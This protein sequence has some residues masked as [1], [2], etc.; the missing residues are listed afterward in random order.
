MKR[1][2]STQNLAAKLGF[3]TRPPENVDELEEDFGLTHSQTFRMADYLFEAKPIPVPESQMELI[4]LL[5]TLDKIY[6]Y[7][8]D[9]EDNAA[10]RKCI[11]NL[12]HSLIILMIS[13]S[14]YITNMITRETD[15]AG[16]LES[17]WVDTEIFLVLLRATL[18]LVQDSFYESTC[19]ATFPEI[20]KNHLVSGRISS[21]PILSLN[22]VELVDCFN[23]FANRWHELRF[24][25]QLVDYLDTL[26]C[27]LASMFFI[28]QPPEYSGKRADFEVTYPDGRFTIAYSMVRNIGWAVK[29]MH[30]KIRVHRWFLDFSASKGVFVMPVFSDAD[31]KVLFEKCIHIDSEDDLQ[32][33]FLNFCLNYLLLP[34]E[35]EHFK[36]AKPFKPPRVD[37]VLKYRM[38][39]GET[40]KQ[41]LEVL[42]GPVK[43]IVTDTSQFGECIGDIAML[44]LISLYASNALGIQYTEYFVIFYDWLEKYASQLH[45]QLSTRNYPIILQSFNWFGIYHDGHYYQHNNVLNCMLHWMKII[46]EPPFNYVVDGISILS[47]D[48]KDYEFYRLFMQE[49]HLRL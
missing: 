36:V 10:N 33:V 45:R 18:F 2:F 31:R 6:D 25:P 49:K 47:L 28:P 9:L 42:S 43:N 39:Y 26:L 14:A 22:T 23:L 15:L 27:R 29:N 17:A 44:F 7:L 19:K 34:G 8:E 5:E 48:L 13:D 35:S 40:L 3:R 21:K 38:G 1:R 4:D 30:R 37:R 16:E 12:R 41:H 32:R 11:W 46:I 24:S 20:V